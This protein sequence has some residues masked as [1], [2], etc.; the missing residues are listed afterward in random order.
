MAMFAGQQK[1]AAEKNWPHLCALR[2]IILNQLWD[3]G[4][5]PAD[6]GKQAHAEAQQVTRAASQTG[7]RGG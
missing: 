3:L 6:Y 4:K 1:T 2:A 5:Q 7:R